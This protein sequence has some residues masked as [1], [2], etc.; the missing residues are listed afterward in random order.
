MIYWAV[1][2]CVD[3]V[4]V[5]CGVVYIDGVHPAVDRRKEGKVSIELREFLNL[6]VLTRERHLGTA[7]YIVIN[8]INIHQTIDRSKISSIPKILGSSCKRPSTTIQHLIGYIT[9]IIAE[10]CGFI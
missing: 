1:E 5:V 10:F 2:I 9:P 8:I 3:I 6:L 4:L 7:K